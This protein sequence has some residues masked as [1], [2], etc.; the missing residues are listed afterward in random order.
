MQLPFRL[1]N[2]KKGLIAGLLAMPF[3]SPC[4]RET[5]RIVEFA[6]ESFSITLAKS[7][8]PVAAWSARI[9]DL[10]RNADELEF[11]NVKLSTES[12]NV[13]V[14]KNCGEKGLQLKLIFVAS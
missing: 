7:G 12:R 1:S 14:L 8:P 9:R 10:C 2:D 6:Q 4:D 5:R 3:L 13:G 11:L